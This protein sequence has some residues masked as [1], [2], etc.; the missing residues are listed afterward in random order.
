VKRS[1]SLIPL[2]PYS[3]RDLRSRKGRSGRAT[4]LTGTEY[5]AAGKVPASQRR[6]HLTQLQSSATEGT[7]RTASVGLWA[8]GL[9]TVATG[10][11]GFIRTRVVDVGVHPKATVYPVPGRDS[12]LLGPL[13]Q[14]ARTGAAA[15]R[16]A[17]GCRWERAA[18]ATTAGVT[19]P[20]LLDLAEWEVELGL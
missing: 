6:R 12:E 4:A 8:A 18:Q 13:G 3:R 20:A 9:S 2:R 17:T 15:R 5:C 19:A 14:T 1:W 10:L 7:T 16:Q 11:L